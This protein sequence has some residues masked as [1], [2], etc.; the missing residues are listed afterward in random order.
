MKKK[1]RHVFENP[2]SSSGSRST[3]SFPDLHV[4]VDDG[5]HER[6][7]VAALGDED[8]DAVAQVTHDVALLLGVPRDQLRDRAE[9]GFLGGNGEE[10]S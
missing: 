10:E 3:N 5:V 6:V 4:V 9:V 1:S 2:R 7:V 8:G